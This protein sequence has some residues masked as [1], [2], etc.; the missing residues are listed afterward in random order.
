MDKKRLTRIFIFFTFLIL[1]FCS[2]I[3][4]ALSSQSTSILSSYGKINYSTPSPTPTPSPTLSQ[5][6]VDGTQLKDAKGNVVI[7]RGVTYQ[8][9]WI[10][11]LSTSVTQNQFAYLKNMG[12]TAVSIDVW[13]WQLYNGQLS[14]DS[15]FWNKLDVMMA[16]AAA[17]DLYVVLCGYTC[18][19]VLGDGY[20]PKD[21]KHVFSVYD[22]WSNWLGYWQ[23]Y[24]D[25]Y[26][27]Y[28]HIIYSPFKECL[29]CD[30]DDYSYYVTQCIDT[31]RGTGGYNTN[32]VIAI[33]PVNSE[34][35][36]ASGM[37]NNVGFHFQRPTESPISRSNIIF[38]ADPYGYHI[39][40]QCPSDPTAGY[41]VLLNYF[42]TPWVLANGYPLFMGETGPTCGF[43]GY[44]DWRSWDQTFMETWFAY[45][46]GLGYSGY[47]CCNY[48]VGGDNG[49][50]IADW[51]GTP[52]SYGTAMRAYYLEH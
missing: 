36:F 13:N 35:D 17:N 51:S 10:E 11:G 23:D 44:S 43:S 6:H 45:L 8:W 31:I 46:D 1:F 29:D 7:L 40:T 19:G 32:A 16:A 14:F 41:A 2:G 37:W 48:N 33:H 52:T 5:L 26:K 27:N 49:Y 4:P 20:S 18:E 42:D 39:Y 34:A 50:L 38:A 12:C 21:L 25:R 28:N 9:H 30:Y 24:A 3:Q 22:T 47:F 15:T